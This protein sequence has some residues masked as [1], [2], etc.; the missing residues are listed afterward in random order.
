VT[1]QQLA[2]GFFG[3]TMLALTVA[4]LLRRERA[5]ICR[6]FTVYLSWMMVADLC[7]LVA[8]DRFWTWEF[9]LFKQ[10]V[11]DLLELAIAVEV[12]YWI[13]LGFPGAARSARGIMFLFLA[14]TLVAVLMLPH[15]TAARDQSDLMLGSLRVRLEV[16]VAWMFAAIAALV[17]WYDIPLPS[18][19]RS[20]IVGFVIHLFVFSTVLEAVAAH[21]YEWAAPLQ[22][23]GPAALAAICCW[24]AW[25]AWRPEP[26][27]EVAPEFMAVL[28]PWRSR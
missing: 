23:F 18:I 6:A 22:S 11:F 26:A 16:G 27:L 5:G 13:F 10:T 4:G 25:T 19:H 12:A 3:V 8:P 1:L 2:I 28:Q 7:V 20:I 17:R 9:W 21:G 24:W 14:G 15:E